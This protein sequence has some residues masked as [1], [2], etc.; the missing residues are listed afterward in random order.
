MKSSPEAAASSERG[1]TAACLL[2]LFRRDTT[3]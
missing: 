3:R 2:S 1:A